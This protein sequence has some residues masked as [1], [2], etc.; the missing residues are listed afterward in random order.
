MLTWASQDKQI[1][2]YPVDFDKQINVTCTHP[3]HLSDHDMRNED[4]EA[5]I[6]MIC[7]VSGRTKA[8]SV[9][10]LQ[11]ESISRHSVVNLQRL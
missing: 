5:A 8:D 3:V 9:Y 10:S 7:R 6:G 2:L 11:S 4:N 1:L